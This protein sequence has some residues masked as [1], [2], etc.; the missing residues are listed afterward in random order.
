[1]NAKHA[2]EAIII[3]I[4]LCLIINFLLSK[5]RQKPREINKI[6]IIGLTGKKPILD[7]P[8]EYNP[9]HEHNN[10]VIKLFIVIFII[11]EPPIELITA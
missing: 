7:A 4:I 1:M 9:I 2:P 3:N 10:S 5:V 8:T 11:T 6:P